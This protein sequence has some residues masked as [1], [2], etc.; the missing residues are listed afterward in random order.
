MVG[1]FALFRTEDMD[2]FDHRHTRIARLL[3]RQDRRRHCRQITTAPPACSR[4]RRSNATRTQ[5]LTRAGSE[6]HSLVYIDIDQ[7][8]LINENFG[9]HIWRCHDRTR[10]RSWYAARTITRAVSARLAG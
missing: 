9:M 1:F 5:N 4:A 7:M 6:T 8:H 10:W 2:D 3:A